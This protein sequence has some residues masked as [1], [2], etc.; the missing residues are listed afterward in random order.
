MLRPSEV[1]LLLQLAE[2]VACVHAEEQVLQERSFA[3]F[4]NLGLR[5]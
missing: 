2:A 3:G 5:V 1:Q 4:R